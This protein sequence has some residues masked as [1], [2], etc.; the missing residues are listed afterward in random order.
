MTS[1]VSVPCGQGNGSGQHGRIVHSV[2]GK[3]LKKA[4]A[5]G[6]QDKIYP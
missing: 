3:K 6:G 1:E 5:G 4:P 2:V